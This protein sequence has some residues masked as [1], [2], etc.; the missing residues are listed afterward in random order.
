MLRLWEWLRQ[1]C[2]CCAEQKSLSKTYSLIRYP[3]NTLLEQRLSPS[4]WI[5]FPSHLTR[6]G[7]TLRRRDVV[8]P[9]TWTC[10]ESI[11]RYCYGD[12]AP[13]RRIIPSPLQRHGLSPFRK[14]NR[15]TLPLL[16]SCASVRFLIQIPSPK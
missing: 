9:P 7:P 6:Q 1:I 14:S 10:T 15:L 2:S 4:R 3:K 16:T 5:F 13:F 11:V 12:A 8:S